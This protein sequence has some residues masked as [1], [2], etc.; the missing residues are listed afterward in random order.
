MFACQRMPCI[1]HPMAQW[2]N[3]NLVCLPLCLVG[4]GELNSKQLPLFNADSGIKHKA[5]DRM[6]I[7]GLGFKRGALYRLYQKKQT[8]KKSIAAA[9][10]WFDLGP[11][12]ERE[13]PDSPCPQIAVSRFTFTHLA[14]RTWAFDR[15]CHNY[16]RIMTREPMS[17]R[18]VT[19]YPKLG[20]TVNFCKIHVDYALSLLFSRAS[21][22]G[23]WVK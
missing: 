12:R 2:I 15:P 5:A 18:T 9:R 19:C 10:D 20:K 8:N 7:D 3:F 22:I 4:P 17:A 1:T 21:K 6:A 23:H 11:S 13:R 14:V 16:R